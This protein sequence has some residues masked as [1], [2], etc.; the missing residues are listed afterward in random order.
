VAENTDARRPRAKLKGVCGGAIGLL[1]A[2][3]EMWMLLGLLVGA[4]FDVLRQ[5]ANKANG[6]R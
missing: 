4:V 5:I 3:A 6:A 2:N 1:T